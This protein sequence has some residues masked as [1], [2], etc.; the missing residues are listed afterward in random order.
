M[1]Q[2]YDG[3]LVGL[4]QESY[5]IRIAFLIRDIKN[6]HCL[7]ENTAQRKLSLQKS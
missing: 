4:L 5:Q 7:L 3:Y 6:E 2:D 1:T